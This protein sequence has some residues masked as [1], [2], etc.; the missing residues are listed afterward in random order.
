MKAEVVQVLVY[1]CQPLHPLRHT[2]H[3]ALHLAKNRVGDGYIFWH[4]IVDAKRTPSYSLDIHS[5]V[6]QYRPDRGTNLDPILVELI[7]EHIIPPKKS[8]SQILEDLIDISIIGLTIA[9]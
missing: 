9:L 1:P 7:V 4:V 5:S 3:A 8:K 6:F 2:M